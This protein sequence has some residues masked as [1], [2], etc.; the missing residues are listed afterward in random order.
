MLGLPVV[1][2]TG[3]PA[4][5]TVVIRKKASMVLDAGNRNTSSH[6]LLR[7]AVLWG[8]SLALVFVLGGVGYL[9][10]LGTIGLV[11]ETEPLFAE[12]ARQMLVTGDWITPYFNGETR[13]DKPPLIYWAM[14]IAYKLVGVN[15]W[16]VRLPSALSAIG[17]VMLVGFSLFKFAHPN[18]L[19]PEDSGRKTE[20]SSSTPLPAVGSSADNW[21]AAWLGICISALTPLIVAWGRTGVSDMLLTACITGSMLSFFH[22]Y[23][24]QGDRRQ[25]RMWYLVFYTCI[26]LGILTKGPVAIVLPGLAIVAFLLYVGC[27]LKVLREA[28]VVR[29]LLAIAALSVPWF[30]VV[31]VIHGSDYIDSFFGYHNFDRFTSVVNNH[32]APWY[33]YFPIVLGGF[34]PFSFDLPAA[35][36]RLKL[37]Q[38]HAWTQQSRPYQLGVFAGWWFVTVFVFF[39]ISVTKL[40]SYVLPLLPAAAIMVA[41]QWS[42]RLLLNDLVSQG[43]PAQPSIGIWI[44]TTCN[45]LFFVALALGSLYFTH[46][47]GADS[48]APDLPNAIQTAR[49]PLLGGAIW[50][51]T[52]IVAVGVVLTG[53]LKWLCLVNIAGM[54]AFVIVVVSVAFPLMDVQRQL[55]LRQLSLLAAEEIQPHEAMLMIGFKKP[56][57]TFYMQQNVR[58][59]SGRSQFE[60]E[61]D[62]ENTVDRL[63]PALVLGERNVGFLKPIINMASCG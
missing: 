43:K 11:D 7:R 56:S 54:L 21:V 59:L 13:F 50:G 26:G 3:S 31:G 19:T 57:V 32:S 34:A 44:Q 1:L 47:L 14:A 41:L 30:V 25:Q 61:F 36:G 38:R 2:K 8:I 58:Y 49:L 18:G 63:P 27:F 46:F 29:G 37:W 17:V 9:W 45:I 28:F 22:A 51:T 42:D 6:I 20:D 24:S 55:P 35:F 52:A 60:R 16:G 10:K 12:A 53:R 33:F 62:P 15:E 5:S 48:S 39:S 23:A 40:P 4:F